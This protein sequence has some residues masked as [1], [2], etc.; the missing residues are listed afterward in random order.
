[1]RP[2]F[3][4]MKILCLLFVSLLC[5]TS[6]LSCAAIFTK[7][8]PQT[9]H[10]TYTNKPPLGLTREPIEKYVPGSPKVVSNFERRPTSA[11][12]AF[13][14]ISKTEQHQRDVA[15][16]DILLTELETEKNRLATGLHQK[17]DSTKIHRIQQNIRS[18][19]REIGSLK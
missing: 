10:V 14:T 11:P 1:M 8:D 19:Q 2:I 5:L 15:R 16:K 4:K 17:E 13:P 7:I 18:L 9:G 3:L 12:Q 6:G